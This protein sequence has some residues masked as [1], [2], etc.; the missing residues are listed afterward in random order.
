[1]IKRYKNDFSNISNA[2]AMI[3]K[4]AKKRRIMAL[5]AAKAIN[6]EAGLGNKLVA[7]K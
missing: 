6:S 1:M 2:A 3:T 4:N 7:I 5:S